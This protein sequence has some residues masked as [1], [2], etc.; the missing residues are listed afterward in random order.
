MD[1]FQKLG[2]HTSLTAARLQLKSI[3]QLMKQEK[4]KKKRGSHTSSKQGR[5]RA[6]TV[7]RAS[8]FRCE[9][10]GNTLQ[11][12]T[13]RPQAMQDK[14]GTWSTG[15]RPRPLLNTVPPPRHIVE[16]FAPDPIL[17]MADIS[18]SW[19]GPVGL[20]RGDVNSSSYPL[21]PTSLGSHGR[22]CDQSLHH[23]HTHSRYMGNS[24]ES[25]ISSCSSGS[26]DHIP[27]LAHSNHHAHLPHPTHCHT[28]PSEVLYDYRGRLDYEL[29]DPP[30]ISSTGRSTALPPLSYTSSISLSVDQETLERGCGNS[31]DELTDEEDHMKELKKAG[32]V[33]ARAG[34]EL[35]GYE[36]ALELGI[37]EGADKEWEQWQQINEDEQG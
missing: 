16:D 13:C 36:G 26:Y 4:R 14:V 21:Q 18:P 6:H 25:N 27:P 3:G 33:L 30:D 17:V 7:S 1:V 15:K 19:A 28:H 35:A 20:C 12:L 23:G 2:D 37:E 5:L 10:P 8:N 11:G 9:M 24:L 22:S 29:V 32:L 34:L 31:E